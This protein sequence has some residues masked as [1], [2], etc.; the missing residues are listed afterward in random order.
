MSEAGRPRA[1]FDC[2]TFVSAMAF[3][4]GPAADAFRLIEAGA[5]ELV[6]DVRP[7]DLLQRIPAEYTSAQGADTIRVHSGDDSPS[8][9]RAINAMLGSVRTGVLSV[10][11]VVKQFPR[12]FFAP[13][14]LRGELQFLAGGEI[15]HP[16]AAA[17]N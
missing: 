9:P 4:E 5:A 15:P 1:I 10:P 12:R 16:A 2:N 7:F 6:A 17:M 13:S 8:E 14:R 3:D 11:S